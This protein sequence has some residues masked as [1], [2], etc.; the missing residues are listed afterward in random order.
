MSLKR[1]KQDFIKEN[2]IQPTQK[3][4]YLDEK[5]LE[6]VDYIISEFRQKIKN[7]PNIV[8]EKLERDFT[9]KF[10]YN[11]N[12]IEGNTIDQ[13]ETAALLDKKIVPEGKSLREIYEITNTEKAL[14]YLKNLKGDV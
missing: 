4:E 9:I 5:K 12:A 8:L 2:N 1:L 6:K 7:Y 11:T 10:T 14:N 3:Y 13:I